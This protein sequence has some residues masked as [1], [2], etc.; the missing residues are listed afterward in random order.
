MRVLGGRQQESLSRMCVKLR[1]GDAVKFL[2]K[3]MMLRGEDRED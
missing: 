1:E 2:K 3:L